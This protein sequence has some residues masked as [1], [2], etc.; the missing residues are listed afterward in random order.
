M[1]TDLIHEVLNDLSIMDV[2]IVDFSFKPHGDYYP[3]YL[4][5]EDS[6]G[7]Q[8]KLAISS[9]TISVGE[10]GEEQYIFLTEASLGK[11]VVVMKDGED[12]PL[13]SIEATFRAEYLMSRPDLNKDALK[14]F[15]THNGLHAIWPFWRQFVY[16]MMPRLRLP[17]PE[18]PLR[19]PL[20]KKKQSEA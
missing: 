16:D 6:L 2:Y 18:I 10:D 7:F 15:A 1:N 19:E 4:P 20:Y 8:D 11:R 5:E 9:K 14:E 3:R 13:F 12:S 17:I